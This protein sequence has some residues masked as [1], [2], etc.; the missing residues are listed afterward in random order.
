MKFTTKASACT[1]PCIILISLLLTTILGS[2]LASETQTE[3]YP[4]DPGPSTT[5][6]TA[7][8]APTVDG[9]IT[10]SSEGS[11]TEA[12]VPS[13][14]PREKR[15]LLFAQNY[16]P[17]SPMTCDRFPRICRA[18]GSPGPDCCKKRCVDVMTDRLN[19]GWC[20]N[21]CGYGEACCSGDC[22][23]IMYDRRNCGGCR[24]RCKRGSYCRY[25]MCSY[26]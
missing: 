3:D 2:S 26:A 11:T 23:N 22:V 12:A 6:T 7:T 18:T 24:K 14:S 9:G 19:C 8:R 5:T 20:G 25:G 1:V 16:N 13:I 17:R 10:T 21:R 15:R 4:G